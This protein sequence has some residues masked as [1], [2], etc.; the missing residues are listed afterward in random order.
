MR[1]QQDSSLVESVLRRSLVRRP[2]PVGFTDRVMA[3]IREERRPRPLKRNLAWFFPKISFRMGFALTGCVCAAMV[4]FTLGLP[5]GREDRN[6]EQ[7]ALHGAERELA[8]VLQLAGN[9]WNQAQEAAFSPRMD[10]N[11]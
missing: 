11:K 2:A 6:A 1:S 7:A 10:N 9:K 4:L 5:T 3:A 8:E